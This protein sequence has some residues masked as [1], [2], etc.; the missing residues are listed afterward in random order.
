MENPGRVVTVD[1]LHSSHGIDDV[2]TDRA[3]VYT[4]KAPEGYGELNI[5]CNSQGPGFEEKLKEID[6]AI[7]GDGLKQETSTKWV[8]G[9]KEA[10]MGLHQ[11]EGTNASNTVDMANSLGP[12]LRPMCTKGDIFTMGLSTQKPKGDNKTR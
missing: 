12:P 8:E 11:L 9:E 2:A 7:F 4:S 10:M 6:D 1:G 5:P 3:K